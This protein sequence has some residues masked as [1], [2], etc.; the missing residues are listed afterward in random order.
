MER[1]GNAY[2]LLCILIEIIFQIVLIIYQSQTIVILKT[3]NPALISF[4]VENSCSDG[5][6]QVAFKTINDNISQDLTRAGVG[7]GFT[8]FSLVALLFFLCTTLVICKKNS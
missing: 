6:L 2:N 8:V 5:P 4:A 7:L 3:I 1:I